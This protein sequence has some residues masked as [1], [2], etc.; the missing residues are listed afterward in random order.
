MAENAVR[1]PRFQPLVLADAH[2]QYFRH[3]A[4]GKTLPFPGLLQ[5][6]SH[7]SSSDWQTPERRFLQCFLKEFAPCG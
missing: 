1:I 2:A 3:L 5:C 7:G 6:V 4:L